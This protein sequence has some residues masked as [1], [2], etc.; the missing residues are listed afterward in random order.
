MTFQKLATAL[1]LSTYSVASANANVDCFKTSTPSNVVVNKNS[2]VQTH[3]D[4]AHMMSQSVGLPALTVGEPR[5]AAVSPNQVPSANFL[6]VVDG[7]TMDGEGLGMV[8][9]CPY[10]LQD[11]N[12]DFTTYVEELMTPNHGQANAHHLMDTLGDSS[13]SLA[14]SYDRDAA[15]A[16]L[17]PH[18]SSKPSLFSEHTY[19]YAW[20]AK[21]NKYKNFVSKSK[22]LNELEVTATMVKENIDELTQAVC[23]DGD[24][25]VCYM[26]TEGNG[27]DLIVK[28][29]GMEEDILMS[30]NDKTNMKLLSEL[31]IINKAMTTLPLNNK[32]DET[33]RTQFYSF[34]VSTLPLMK[35]SKNKA[36]ANSLV[37][38]AINKWQDMAMKA[39][40]DD[41]VVSVVTHQEV[42]EGVNG[43]V[44][45]KKHRKAAKGYGP[46][47]VVFF[48]IIGWTTVFLIGAMWFT[49]YMQ[50]NLDPDYNSIIFRTTDSRLKAE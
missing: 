9:T 18:T 46:N 49:I 21:F 12:V 48:H 39:F 5:F 33:Q 3:A 11:S 17:S 15:E 23:G 40:E 8:E 4:V 25:L 41:V 30:L 34:A 27:Q 32:D 44:D 14:I 50:A 42:V 35:D 47:F 29:D 36:A 7:T 20:D 1:V 31:Y 28:V 19:G 10:P 43:G 16:L 13:S 38:A 2:A 26:P 6:F 37:N 24:S 22:R 45:H